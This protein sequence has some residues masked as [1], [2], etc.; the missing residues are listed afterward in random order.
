MECGPHHS[1]NLGMRIHAQNHVRITTPC[2]VHAP[3]RLGDGESL[4]RGRT[5][6]GKVPK[7]AISFG[8]SKH[9]LSGGYEGLEAPE[10]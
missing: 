5:L 9:H 4:K 3:S 7:S 1:I 6:M 10:T 8:F 2:S